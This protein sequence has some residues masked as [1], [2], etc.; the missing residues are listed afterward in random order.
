MLKG[1][2]IL[3]ITH[4][5]VPLKALQHCIVPS[6]TETE[7]QEKLSTL[8]NQFELEEL[9]YLATCN[10]VTYFFFS[11]KKLNPSF[12]TDFLEKANPSFYPTFSNGL[13]SG[14]TLLEGEEALEHLLDVAS[15]I[16]SMVV[17][18]REILRQLRTAYTQSKE[19]NLTGDH[20]RMA[21]RLAVETAK[22]VYSET[23]IGEKPVS[24]VSLAIQKLLATNFPKN[25]KLLL[26]GAGQTNLL[27]SKF[28]KKHEFQNVTVFNRSIEKAN[29]LANMLDGEAL[30]LSEL[31]N[32]S[33]GFDGIIICTGSDK[34]IIDDKL[35]SAL[36]QGDTTR[37]LIIDLA[38]PNNVE[39]SVVENFNVNYIEIEGLKNLAKENLSF[40]SQEVAK[41]KELIAEK[42]AEFRI[43]HQQRQI[44]KAMSSVP[45]EI[46]AVKEHAMNEVFKKDLEN[47]DDSARELLERMMTYMEKRCIG[48]PMKAAK[49]LVEQ[50]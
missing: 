26:V 3:T 50:K 40:R 46:K 43:L 21:E 28:L 25:G 6:E 22:K 45:K 41:A 16:D 5:Q 49:E 10:R 39:K 30:L 35:Y 37:K 36:L 4:K 13:R 24:V 48:I 18:E 19:W 34:A 1:F 38:I 14:I 42:L 20:M 29:S 27:V 8:K 33:G 31:E 7:L 11:E 47:L 9:L 32:Y 17:G 15:S 2:K 44:Q 23:R 12:A